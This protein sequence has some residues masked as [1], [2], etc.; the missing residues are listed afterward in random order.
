M[1]G[2]SDHVRGIEA[3]QRVPLGPAIRAG[4]YS[5]NAWLAATLRVCAGRVLPSNFCSDCQP[6]Q[7]N[8][9]LSHMLTNGQRARASCRSGSL[10]I[11][12]IDRP[13]VVDVVG[14]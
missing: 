5:K 8:S 4:W 3:L 9:W 12:A 13:V 6:S 14:M 2:A 7:L 11:S 1:I 10:Q